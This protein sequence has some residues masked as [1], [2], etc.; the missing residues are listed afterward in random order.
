MMN[1]RK[2]ILCWFVL[3]VVLSS[4]C[5]RQSDSEVV[6]TTRDGKKSKDVAAV[7]GDL[8]YQ[9]VGGKPIPHDA[10]LLHQ[11][12]RKKGEAGDYNSALRLLEQA[13]QI[14][15]GWAYPPARPKK[16]LFQPILPVPFTLSGEKGSRSHRSDVD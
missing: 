11:Q 5:K 3:V 13:S 14:A 10:E 12:A 4:S 15:P 8:S 16:P 1:A 6:Y 7:G 2:L 9:V